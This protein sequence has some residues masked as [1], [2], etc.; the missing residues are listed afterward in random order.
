MR[1]EPENDRLISSKPHIL[2][3][4]DTESEKIIYRHLL[5]FEYNVTSVASWPEAQKA[6]ANDTYHLVLIDLS[7]PDPESFAICKEL[8]TNQSTKALPIIFITPKEALREKLASLSLTEDDFLSKPANPLQLK[9]K[10]YARVRD[11]KIET[12]PALKLAS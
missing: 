4:E 10:I 8:K 2:I 12:P 7:L 5:A 1:L 9:A 11:V 6:L 3:L